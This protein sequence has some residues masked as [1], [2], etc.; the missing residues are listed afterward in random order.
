VTDVHPS[1]RSGL[2]FGRE[3]AA[4]VALIEAILALALAFGIGLTTETLGATMAVVTAAAGLYVAWSTRDTL[5]GATVGLIKSALILAACYG[6]TLSDQQS[7]ALIALV[8]VAFG[9]FNRQVTSPVPAGYWGSLRASG[10]DL[11][12]GPAN[13][14]TPDTPPL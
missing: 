11:G 7:A 14:G 13:L 9:L 6:L 3:P 10:G 5:L 12:H 4:I 8:V 2:I 1:I